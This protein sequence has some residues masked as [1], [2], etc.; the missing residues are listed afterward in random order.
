[1]RWGS[2]GGRR[3]WNP[4]SF[5]PSPA[6]AILVTNANPSEFK[7]FQLS[8]YQL[9]DP[10]KGNDPTMLRRTFHAQQTLSNYRQR[11]II[12]QLSPSFLDEKE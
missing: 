9:E 10:N 7:L 6:A 12:P 5:H 8:R 2:W 11:K 3:K 4:G 1:V